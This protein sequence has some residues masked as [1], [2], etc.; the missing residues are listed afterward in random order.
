MRSIAST[1]EHLPFTRNVTSTASR[2]LF[3][4]KLSAA[5]WFLVAVLGQLIFVIYIY[6]FY[7]RAAL[8]GD[9]QAWNKV[10]PHGYVPGDTLGNIAI[11]VHLFFAAAITLAGAA[12]LTPQ[13]RAYAPRLHRWTGRGYLSAAVLMS[14]SGLIMVWTRSTVGDLSQHVAISL[15]ALLILTS[16]GFALRDAMTRRIDLHRRWAL[17][18]FLAVS[19]VWFFRIGLMLWIVLN[20]G[21]VGFDSKTFTGPFLTCLAFGVYVFIPWTVL[22]LYFRAQTTKSGFAQFAMAG[23]LATITLCMLLGV[24]AATMLMWLPQL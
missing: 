15:N 3:A 24:A 12:Q 6:G 2:P 17:R 23:G 7:G 11:S 13:L 9:F 16:A 14:I 8:N 5:L 4:L 18:L 21:P 19:G 22:E 10:M 1:P 20:Q